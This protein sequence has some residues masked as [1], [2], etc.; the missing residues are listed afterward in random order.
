M[1]HNRF[2]KKCSNLKLD[3]HLAGVG[4]GEE[5]CHGVGDVLEPLDDRLLGLDLALP[6][7]LRHLEDALHPP[8]VPP[9]ATIQHVL[10]V[11]WPHLIIIR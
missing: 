2:L 6:D 7:P 8:C 3:D 9:E 4:S 5:S 1:F 11:S 10:L